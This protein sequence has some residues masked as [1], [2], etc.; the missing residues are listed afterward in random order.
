MI[1][2]LRTFLLVLFLLSKLACA[3]E[4]GVGVRLVE[5]PDPVTRQPM[6]AALFYPSDES[7]KPSRIGP[8]EIAATRDATAQGGRH[9]L[10]LLSHGNGGGMFSHHDT[11]EYLARHG[12]V[13]AA[14]EHPGD[15]F[16]DASGV[17]SDRVLV[18]RSAQLSA[19]L[20]FLISSPEFSALVD[21]TRIGVTGFS[22]GGYTAL[23]AVGARP[24]LARI[25]SYCARH[26]RS[27]LCSGGGSVALSAPP[28]VANADARIRAAFVMSPVAAY[29]D[30]DSLAPIVAPVAVYA[31]GEDAVLP[32][33]DNA[34]WLRDRLAT[35]VTYTEIAGADHFVFLAPCTAR[36]ADINPVLCRDP[37]GTDRRAIHQSINAALLDFFSAQL[38]AR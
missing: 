2:F 26:A 22:A 28:L 16:H 34:R 7:L 38:A 8:L 21:A 6:K 36:M 20:D 5:T 37:P 4:A 24:R 9:P 14:I 30:D 18:G 13:V 27:V 25:E 15:N 31:A 11:A 12:F 29:F 19:L 23:V 3:G 32:I 35:L 17:G 33:A 1:T 10:I